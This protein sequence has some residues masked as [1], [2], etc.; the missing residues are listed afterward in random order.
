MNDFRF[1]N[2]PRVS[3]F[4]ACCSRWPPA[5]P[6]LPRLLRSGLLVGA[7]PGHYKETEATKLARNFTVHGVDVSK[8]QGNVNWDGGA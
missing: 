4:R 8:Y 6:R 1:E 5:A 3:R 7:R 2:H